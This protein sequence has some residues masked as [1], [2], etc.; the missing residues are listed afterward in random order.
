ML[1][2]ANLLFGT[3]LITL[4]AG[5]CQGPAKRLNAP[6]QGVSNQPHPLQADM[7]YMV[8][9][10]ML[11]D[12]SVVDIHF[13]PHTDEIS[14][15]GARRLNRYAEMLLQIGGT[16][17]YDA[18]PREDDELIQARIESVKTFLADAGVDLDKVTV[19]RGMSRGRGVTAREHPALPPPDDG[20][21]TQRIIHQNE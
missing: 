11:Y 8:D 9:N 4:L 20:I 5:A 15:L 12:M 18:S 13:V 7:T 16:I 3:A 17:H 14:S 19:E 6:P 21:P 1:L 2:R 10:G